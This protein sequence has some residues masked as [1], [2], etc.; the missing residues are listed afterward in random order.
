MPVRWPGP[1]PASWARPRVLQASRPETMEGDPAPL[2]DANVMSQ[3]EA[4]RAWPGPRAAGADGGC[5]IVVFGGHKMWLVTGI[6]LRETTKAA[7]LDS[8]A[9][10][11]GEPT[12]R[13]PHKSHQ[14]TIFEQ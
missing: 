4:P 1:R 7:E 9:F 5:R 10:W 8:A 12:T 13:S 2:R 14:V 6:S 3:P 11:R